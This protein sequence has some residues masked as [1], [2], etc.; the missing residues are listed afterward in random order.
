M[1]KIIQFFGF[2]VTFILLQIIGDKFILTELVTVFLFLVIFL[3]FDIKFDTKHIFAP[4]NLFLLIYF[5]RLYL[6]PISAIF[7]DYSHWQYKRYDYDKVF[8]GHLITLASYL[9][10]SIGWQISKGIEK[11]KRNESINTNKTWKKHYY[12]FLSKTKIKIIGWSFLII[13]LISLYLYFGDLGTYLLNIF[14]SKVDEISEQNKGS[15]LLGVISSFTK[16]FL[17]FSIYCYY[18]LIDIRKKPVIKKVFIITVSVIL[19]ILFTLNSNR[20]SMVYP[21]FALIVTMVAERRVKILPTLII[22]VIAFNFLFQFQYLRKQDG[23]SD[24]SNVDVGILE[25][26]QNV[27]IYIGGSQMVT[28]IFDD[29]QPYHF[30]IFDSVLQNIPILGKPYRETSGVYYYNV[31]FYKSNVGF[32]QVYLTHA[33]AY[34]SGG[35]ILLSVIFVLIGFFYQKMNSYYY[36]IFHSQFL[37]RAMFYYLF[38]LFNSLILLSFQVAG[39]YLVFNATSGFLVWC[40]YKKNYI[41]IIWRK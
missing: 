13:G 6:L 14:G 32:D 15:Q 41:K 9:M 2:L 19:M 17:P 28:P 7:Y 25:Q 23:F 16:Y 36:K 18:S 12:Y 8:L 20:Q 35:I 1:S 34:K 4:V 33:E 24:K 3:I 39:Q 30:T 5:F 40:I 38:L 21:L 26:V 22:F 29:L 31:L 37:Y 11:R 10:L 27:Q